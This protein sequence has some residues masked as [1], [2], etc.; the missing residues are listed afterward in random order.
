M[1]GNEVVVDYDPQDDRVTTEIRLRE[2]V[3]PE[4]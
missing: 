4:S 2:D 3:S 1:P